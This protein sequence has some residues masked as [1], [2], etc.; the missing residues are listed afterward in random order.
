MEIE[1]ILAYISALVDVRG[2]MRI[3]KKRGLYRI[4]FNITEQDLDYWQKVIELLSSI[5][6]EVKIYPKCLDKGRLK[7]KH[8]EY[9]VY[10][11]RKE[12][13]RKLLDMIK[14]YSLRKDEYIEILN[15]I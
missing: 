11:G 15:N 13:V 8:R 6:I 1:H 5:G 9:Q 4:S 2:F 3:D 7:G 10:I 12:Q 14:D